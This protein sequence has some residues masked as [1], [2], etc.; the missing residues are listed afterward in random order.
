MT[1]KDNQPAG[2]TVRDRHNELP[3]VLKGMGI[4]RL[5]KWT[6]DHGQLRAEFPD[7][8]GGKDFILKTGDKAINAHIVSVL[9]EL[10]AKMEYVVDM[11]LIAAAIAKYKQEDKA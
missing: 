9:E 10:K 8:A 5:L 2:Q 6:Y 7:Q 4:P 11:K 1:L 3:D